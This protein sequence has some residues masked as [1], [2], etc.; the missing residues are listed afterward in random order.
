[1][2][3]TFFALHYALHYHKYF[4]PKTLN[5]IAYY[6]YILYNVYSRK[7]Y[8]PKYNV[9]RFYETKTKLFTIYEITMLTVYILNAFDVV[10]HYKQT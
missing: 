10:R 7:S 8:K 2:E 3:C 5:S 4:S 6:Q 1:M 9:R